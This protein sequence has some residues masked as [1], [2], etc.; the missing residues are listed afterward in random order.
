MTGQ[1][2]GENSKMKNGELAFCPQRP[3]EINTADLKGQDRRPD[4]RNP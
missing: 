1:E 4:G 2:K 3:M